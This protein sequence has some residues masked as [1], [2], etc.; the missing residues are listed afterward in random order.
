MIE[1]LKRFR[2]AY[3]PMLFM[4]GSGVA[5]AHDD[6]AGAWVYGLVAALTFVLFPPL[7]DRG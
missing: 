5:W 7:L 1:L 6:A 4:F 2:D 3:F